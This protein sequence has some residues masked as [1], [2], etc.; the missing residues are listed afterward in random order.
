M[1]GVRS[2]ITPMSVKVELGQRGSA[3]SQLEEFFT[4]G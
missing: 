1:K 3:T 2:S 4:C